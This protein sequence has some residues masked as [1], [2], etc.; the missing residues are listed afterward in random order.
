MSNK[1]EYS[2]LLLANGEPPSQSLFRHFYQ[3][4]DLHIAL[5]GGAMVFHKQGKEAD[6]LIGDLDSIP[7]D[8]TFSC[9]IIHD[10][11]QETNDLEKGLAFCKKK[12]VPSCYILGATGRR[13][14]HAL[15][16]LSVLAQFDAHFHD[17]CLIDADF[18][19]RLLP[20]TY[21]HHGWK[22]QVISLFPLSGRVEGISTQGLAYPLKNEALE[23]GHRD[24]SSNHAIDAEWSVSHQKGQLIALIQHRYGV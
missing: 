7:N 14:D 12:N 20:K 15:K 24:G 10:P 8:H 1:K 21:R 22:G 2:A 9:P 3:K 6:Y 4:T 23:N 13:L 17:I 16:N 5:D 19:I 18:E 11:D